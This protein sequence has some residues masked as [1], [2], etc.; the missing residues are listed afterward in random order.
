[1]SEPSQLFARLHISRAKYEAFLAS[2][3]R[4]EV[5]DALMAWLDEA[6]YYGPRITRESVPE[7]ASKYATVREWVDDMV[8]PGIMSMGLG[9]I[10]YRNEYDDAT[11][12]WTLAALDFSEN[13][14]DYIAAAGAMREA[15]RFKDLPGDDGLVVYGYMFGNGFEFAV[16][17]DAGASAFLSEE[18]AAPLVAQADA[19]MESLMKQGAARAGEGD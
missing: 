9:E 3:F 8:A 7:R 6:S 16:R 10:P 2:P 17:I 15:A 19:V 5:D 4:V 11:Q 12:T 13:Y 1:M 18:E 14:D